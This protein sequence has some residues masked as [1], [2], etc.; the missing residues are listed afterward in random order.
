[1]LNRSSA[2]AAGLLLAASMFAPAYA[3]TQLANAANS[4]FCNDEAARVA[5]MRKGGFCDQLNDMNSLVKDDGDD[6][7][8]ITVTMNGSFETPRL[9]VAGP[10]PIDPCDPCN[11]G[12]INDLL[13]PGAIDR[14][15]VAAAPCPPY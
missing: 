1:M 2:A 6:G 12:F 11:Y 10:G 15:H 8:S 9:L 4:A 14:V 3:G 7:C 5:Y 13:P